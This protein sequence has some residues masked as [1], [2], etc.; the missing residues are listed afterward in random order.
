[1]KKIHLFAPRRHSEERVC[2][3]KKM[4]SHS[5]VTSHYEAVQG[6]QY[7][8]IDSLVITRNGNQLKTIEDY[9]EKHLTYTGASD[10]YDGSSYGTEYYYNANGALESDI[11]RDIDLI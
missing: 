4:V 8:Q 5:S 6:R 2:S 3:S 1:M 11:N 9:A 10:F 7:G